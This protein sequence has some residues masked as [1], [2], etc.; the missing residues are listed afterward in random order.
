MPKLKLTSSCLP[1][2]GETAIPTAVLSEASPMKISDR[3]KVSSHYKDSSEA[4][5]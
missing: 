4:G 1:H 2:A 5:T 3:Q